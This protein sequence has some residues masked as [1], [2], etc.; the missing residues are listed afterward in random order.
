MCPRFFLA[1]YVAGDYDVEIPCD[2][3]PGEYTIR[4]ARFEDDSLYSCSDAFTIE[5]GGNDSD[6]SG[7]DSSDDSG[8][9]SS[10]DSGDDS[11]DDSSDDD[12]FSMSYRF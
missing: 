9:D 12:D 1:I 4:V 7:D 3:E 2:T 11:L 8:D 5:D 10:D 6:D